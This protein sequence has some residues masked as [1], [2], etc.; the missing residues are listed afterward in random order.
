MAGQRQAKERRLPAFY[1]GEGQVEAIGGEQTAY[2]GYTLTV[3]PAYGQWLVSISQP[4]THGL[5]SFKARDKDSA[6]AK[7]KAWV[8]AQTQSSG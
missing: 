2:H 5:A 6:V 3:V 4:K 8:D 1:L 7:G